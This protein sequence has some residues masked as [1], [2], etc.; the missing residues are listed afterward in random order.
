MSL[1]SRSGCHLPCFFYNS[2]FIQSW[3]LA[4]SH[5]I[6][7]SFE[8][9][10]YIANSRAAWAGLCPP[11]CKYEQVV[12]LL[13]RRP[14]GSDSEAVKGTCVLAATAASTFALPKG[15]NEIL[16]TFTALSSSLVRTRFTF[17]CDFSENECDERHTLRGGHKWNFALFYVL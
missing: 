5:L 16:H 1:V 3:P 4:V 7:R 2:H 9:R 8:K 15:A 12:Q 10:W 6:G 14:G 11:S 17:P 13:I